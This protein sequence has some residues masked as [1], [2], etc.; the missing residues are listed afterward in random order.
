MKESSGA[1]LYLE[2]VFTEEAAWQGRADSC[3]WGEV[4]EALWWVGNT[5]PSI[6][7]F[8]HGFTVPLRWWCFYAVC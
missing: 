3:G 1:V 2:A 8:Q 5:L 7:C 4:V 6:L